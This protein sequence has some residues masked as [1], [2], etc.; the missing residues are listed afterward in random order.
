[1]NFRVREEIEEKDSELEAKT[2]EVD[3]LKLTVEQLK[4]LTKNNNNNSSNGNNNKKNNDSDEADGWDCEDEVVV[5]DFSAI[6]DSA[7][8]KV[9]LRKA[10]EACE[11]L[12]DQLVTSET[13]KETFEKEL[14]VA[15][16]E[17]K[18]ARKAKENAVK[19]KAEIQKKLEVLTTYFN[20]RE[21]DLQKQLGMTANRLTDTASSSESA[22][23]QLGMLQEEVEAYKTQVRSH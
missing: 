13:A 23:K 19:D 12:S 21:S 16:E 7:Q 14:S 17:M 9:D 6:Q 2:T 22:S 4:E 3:V 18:V 5:P 20:Q 15:T 1:M 8:L 10:Q 11:K